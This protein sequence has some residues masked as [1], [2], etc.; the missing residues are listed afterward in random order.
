MKVIVTATN[1]AGEEWEEEVEV[2][3][4]PTDDQIWEIVDSRAE[5]I[6]ARLGRHYTVRLSWVQVDGSES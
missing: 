6:E 3:D 5:E 1:M 2:S 4:A